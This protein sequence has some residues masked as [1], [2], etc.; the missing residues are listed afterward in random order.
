MGNG[1]ANQLA[2]IGKIHF[3]EDVSLVSTDRFHAQ[4]QFEADF[5][6]TSPLDQ[7]VENLI[8][9]IGKQVVG[10]RFNYW[11]NTTHHQ[12]GNLLTDIHAPRGH[13]PNGGDQY[14]T[15]TFLGQ[16]PGSA[17]MNGTDRLLLFVMHAQNKY[18]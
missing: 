14:L 16:I 12:F 9:A 2:S 8:F 10:Q 6:Q 3:L 11:S 1:V 17:G 5:C 7:H 15:V 18:G 4:R 13:T